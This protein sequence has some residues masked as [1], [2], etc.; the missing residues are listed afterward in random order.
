MLQLEHRPHLPLDLRRDHGQ[1]A[2]L[3]PGDAAAPAA[4]LQA[5]GINSLEC[6]L[7]AVPVA[8]Q[9][10]RAETAQL[11]GRSRSTALIVVVAATATADAA[12]SIED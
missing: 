7:V 12:G 9:Q 4:V 1:V 10:L 6:F 11:A 2:G 5:L 8:A 3:A